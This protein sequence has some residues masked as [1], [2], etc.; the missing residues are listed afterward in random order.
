[1]SSQDMA[2]AARKLWR[3]AALVWGL[4]GPGK[5]AGMERINWA[6]KLNTDGAV[7]LPLGHATARGL[8]R[9]SNGDWI[10]GFSVNIGKAS[11][12][13][14]ELSGL[15]EG[16]F[17]AKRNG[18]DQLECKD[19]LEA[20]S[21]GGI[22]HIFEEVN[23]CADRAASMGYLSENG[24]TEYQ[25]PQ[26]IRKLMWEDSRGLLEIEARPL[27]GIKCANKQLKWMA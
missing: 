14:A 11:V 27:I 15:R 7:S 17:F 22:G 1:M 13:A 23:F 20:L 6:R 16:L 25:D 4:K 18:L 8:I 5:N 26:S 21:V 24:V 3:E 2:F 19:L 10:L 9:N 12:F